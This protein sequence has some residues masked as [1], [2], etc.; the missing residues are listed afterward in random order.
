MVECH[1][2]KVDV[3]GSNPFSRSTSKGWFQFA[4]P[5][6]LLFGPRISS[7][8]DSR[9]GNR[10][11]PPNDAARVRAISNGGMN[12]ASRALCLDPLCSVPGMFESEYAAEINLASGQRVSF[13]VDR[14]LIQVAGPEATEGSPP[15]PRIWAWLVPWIDGQ[16]LG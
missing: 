14:A 8:F 9:T 10:G 11:T 4:G 12:D 1:L 3:E 2:A 7:E 6:F 15:R 5:A 16:S 13:F